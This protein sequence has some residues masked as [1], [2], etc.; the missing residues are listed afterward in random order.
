MAY[1]VSVGLTIAWL[2]HWCSLTRDL[3]CST[4]LRLRL[5]LSSFGSLHLGFNGVSL[6]DFT[7]RSVVLCPLRT[8]IWLTILSSTGS[9]RLRLGCRLGL[10]SLLRL[11]LLS[12]EALKLQCLLTTP[13]M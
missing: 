9:G 13:N 5:N 7:Y 10:S 3:R 4:S 12:L 11:G 6:L 8:V 1:L 2:L